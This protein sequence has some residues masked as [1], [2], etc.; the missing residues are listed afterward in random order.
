ME[1]PKFTF[2]LKKTDTASNIADRW[3]IE[4]SESLV[5]TVPTD[6]RQSKITHSAIM[7]ELFDLYQ[8]KITEIF[9]ES[10]RHEVDP[11]LDLEDPDVS[12][13]KNILDEFY[14]EHPNMFVVSLVPVDFEGTI[15]FVVMPKDMNSQSKV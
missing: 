7:L 5:E 3:Y 9:K 14:L 12:D 4:L 10:F 1:L 8:L 2:F 13:L 15:G 6:L 11:Q